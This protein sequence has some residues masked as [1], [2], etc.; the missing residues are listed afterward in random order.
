M[1]KT[2][3]SSKRILLAVRSIVS[4]RLPKNRYD[5]LYP[6][7]GIDFSGKSFIIN[8]ETLITNAFR[9]KPKEVAEYIALASYRS[10]SYYATTGDTTLDLFHSPVEQTT[11]NSNRLLKVIDGRVHFLYEEVP[12][13]N[14]TWH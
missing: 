1:R 8:P 11:I 12:K 2:G 13:E 5:P 7:Y 3:S 4:N 10:Y 14:N 6:F 9:Y